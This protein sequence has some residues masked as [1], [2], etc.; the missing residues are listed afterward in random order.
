MAKFVLFPTALQPGAIKGK[1]GIKFCHLATL[2]KT[3]FSLFQMLDVKL[4]NYRP[5]IELMDAAGGGMFV[6]ASDDIEASAVSNP[7]Y[8]EF[9]HLHN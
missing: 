7:K 5:F 3:T 8:Q 6:T 1:E 2:F 9:A 4:A